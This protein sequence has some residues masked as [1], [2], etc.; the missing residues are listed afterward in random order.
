MTA[1]PCFKSWQTI[2]RGTV[3]DET[4]ATS[5]DDDIRNLSS[6]NSVVMAVLS[7]TSQMSARLT[8]E[9]SSVYLAF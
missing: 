1:Y 9:D 3:E 5:L 8:I 6:T 4:D 2:G 7:L